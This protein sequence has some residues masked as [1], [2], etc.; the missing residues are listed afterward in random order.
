LNKLLFLPLLFV[1]CLAFAQETETIRITGTVV[2]SETNEPVPFVHII[3]NSAR[4]GLTTDEH[5][6]F[7]F[8]MNA[9]DTLVF[10]SVGYEK[11]L[12]V[13]GMH[14]D[15]RDFNIA[16]KPSTTVLQGVEITAFGNEEAFKKEFLALELPEQPKII[17]PGV[18]NGPRREYKPSVLN[19]VSFVYGMFDR[20]TKERAKLVQVQ[21]ESER[22]SRLRK[23]YDFIK[24]IAGI[25]DDEL[26]EFLDYCR[27]DI[28]RIESSSDYELAV[29]V[30]VCI[31]DFKATRISR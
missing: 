18:Y 7:F 16:I 9:K 19:P 29:A 3:N 26:E 10:S 31:P 11:Y 13:P 8:V 20:K 30:N 23:K 2:D 21:Q 6:E 27:L 12:L 5:G 17:L 1:A 24:D 22:W 25:G 4:Q 28:Q 14:G 15:Q